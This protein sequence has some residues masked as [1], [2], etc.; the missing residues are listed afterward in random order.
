MG[1]F[2]LD[3]WVN[4]LSNLG[5]RG[6]DKTTAAEP[7][8]AYSLTWPELTNI[9]MGDGIGARVVDVVA[10]DMTRNGFEVNGDTDNLLQTACQNL[11]LKTVLNNAAK[12]KRLYGG[13]LIM[14][15]TS[16][17]EVDMEQPLPEKFKINAF[18]VYP[19]SRVFLTLDDFNLLNPHQPYYNEPFRFRVYNKWTGQYFTVHRSRTIPVRGKVV[20]DYWNSAIDLQVRYWG[21]SCLQFMR[22]SLSGYGQFMQGLS[23]LGHEMVIGKYTLSGLS[24]L[25]AEKNYKEVMKRIAMINTAKSNINAVVLGEGEEYS[26]DS[27]TF[28]GAGDV[29]DR[30]AMWVSGC[31]G[32]PVSRI[33]GQSKAGLNNSD[34]GSL[35][36]YYD[37]V[38]SDQETYMQPVLL[39]CLANINKSLG[40]P[41]PEDKLG[42][43]WNPVWSPSQKDMIQMRNTQA[44]TDKIYAVDIGAI[45]GEEVATNRFSRGYSFETNLDKAK[46]I[47]WSASPAKEGTQPKPGKANG[48]NG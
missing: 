47:D 21:V 35:T 30:F 4:Y 11:L 8:M 31:S 12:W 14:M 19:A 7:G 2:H 36:N 17:G 37:M 29:V 34:E 23:H 6:V 42:G 18:K 27:I 33:Y 44:Q 41:I 13:A 32:V 24:R 25:L 40:N 20:P 48:T 43:K 38:T 22:D 5:R 1:I 10:D 3:S 39:E 16:D 46:S 28:S 45:T 9:Y 15:E 26:R